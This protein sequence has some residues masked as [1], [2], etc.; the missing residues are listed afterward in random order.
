MELI[1]CGIGT[2]SGTRHCSRQ[3][4]AFRCTHY[5]QEQVAE[6]YPARCAAVAY[7]T[8]FRSAGAC[9]EAADNHAAASASVARHSVSS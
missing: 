1:F 6:H 2:V 9:S 7:W 3:R 5:A 8:L 4:D